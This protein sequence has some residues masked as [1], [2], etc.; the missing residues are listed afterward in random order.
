MRHEREESERQREKEKSESQNP[1]DWLARIRRKMINSLSYACRN[2][3]TA[4]TCLLSNSH[5][6]THTHTHTC[7]TQTQTQHM[8]VH[9]R[10]LSM[11]PNTVRKER[12][13]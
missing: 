2:I 8:R 3:S 7:T 10:I 6:H 1:I 13:G 4:V 9:E 12:A 11:Y 5:T